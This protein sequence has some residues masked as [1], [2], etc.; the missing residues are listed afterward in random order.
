MTRQAARASGAEEAFADEPLRLPRGSCDSQ[1][2]VYARDR[3][4]YPI[5]HDRPLYEAPVAELP[6]ALLMHEQ[7]GLERLVLVQAT[8]Y[9]TDHTLL[10]DSLAQLTPARARGVAI[11]DDSVSDAELKRLDA[12]GVRAARFNFQQRLGLVP[13]LDGFRRSVRRVQDLG[14]FIKIFGGPN[15]LADIADEIKRCEVP[16]VIDHMGHLNQG[17]VINAA[18]LKLLRSILEQKDRWV[19]LSN[20][21]RLSISGYP[22]DDAA[23]I[24]RL[25]YDT[26]PEC[27]IWGSDWPH[28]GS[29]G[30]PMPDD[31][32]LV[33]LLLRYLPDE[34][35]VE[36]VLVRNPAELFGF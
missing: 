14:W 20:G 16:V 2:H 10:L 34:A 17:G 19:M 36:R 9:T 22:W 5:R 8:V 1:L 18:G 26:A 32:D 3:S 11:V 29:L 13:T 24:G 6:D 30:G 31:G 35:A 7:V 15:E 27:C 25:L 23:V 4:T 33:R 28:V 12:A 21:H